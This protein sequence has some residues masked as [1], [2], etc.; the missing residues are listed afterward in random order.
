MEA[1]I[2]GQKATATVIKP[3]V[4]NLTMEHVVRRPRR[5]GS[6]TWVPYRPLWPPSCDKADDFIKS[7]AEVGCLE[8]QDYIPVR[9]CW[10]C[11]QEKHGMGGDQY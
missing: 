8:R 11:Y 1:W 4:I 3:V 2:E 6:V 7:T 9:D 10:R 5:L